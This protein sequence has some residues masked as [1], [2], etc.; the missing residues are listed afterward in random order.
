MDE[1]QKAVK[2]I[3]LTKF[4]PPLQAMSNWFLNR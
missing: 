2:G 1:Y 4:A 3:P